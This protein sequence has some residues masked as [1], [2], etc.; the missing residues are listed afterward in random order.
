[1]MI[2]IAFINGGL[3]R[4]ER[5]HDGIP[6]LDRSNIQRRFHPCIYIPVPS[7]AHM[8]D[9]SECR[10]KIAPFD[11]K[12]HPRC[13]GKPVSGLK[14]VCKEMREKGIDVPPYSK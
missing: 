11:L 13:D 3:N 5:G 4:G 6:G 9:H 2:P 12:V 7:T 14:A 8:S 10:I 1:M